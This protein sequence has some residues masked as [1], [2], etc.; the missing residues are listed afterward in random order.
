METVVSRQFM[1]ETPNV[2]A[3]IPLPPAPWIVTGPRGGRYV[4]T[5]EIVRAYVE[6]PDDFIRGTVTVL[7]VSEGLR[8]IRPS[9][10]KDLEA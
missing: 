1:R 10:A 8:Y 2:N 7:D 6:M 9:R 4:A 3:M 5:G